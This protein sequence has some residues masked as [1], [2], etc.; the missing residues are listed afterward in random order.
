MLLNDQGR[1]LRL[2]HTKNDTSKD[3]YI[4]VNT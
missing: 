4:S 3:N 2:I 1:V